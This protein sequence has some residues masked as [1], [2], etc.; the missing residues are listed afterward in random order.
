V[1]AQAD[2]RFADAQPELPPMAPPG[3]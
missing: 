1:V 3:V 2:I